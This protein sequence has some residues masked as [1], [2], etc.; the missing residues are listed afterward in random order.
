M[1]VIADVVASPVMVT[2]IKLVVSNSNYVWVIDVKW[3]DVHI[4]LYVLLI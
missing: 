2:A 4:L 1:W 3:C